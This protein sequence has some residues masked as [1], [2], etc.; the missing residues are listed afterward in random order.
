MQEELRDL[1]GPERDAY[2]RGVQPIWGGGLSEESF[3]AFQRRLADAREA[4]ERH[5]LIGLFDGGRLLAAMKAYDL[6]GSCA[7]RPL[8]I[9]GIGAVFTPPAL[10][11]RGHARRMLE[12]AI[13][14]HAARGADAAMLFSDIGTRYY[15]RLGFRSLRSE[16]C[17]VEQ[18]D[19]P[20]APS[21]VPAPADEADLV[22]VFA[23]GRSNNGDLTLARDGWVLHFQLRR[24]RELARARGV[25]EPEW[26]I[27]V[28]DAGGEGAAMVRIARDAV[29]VL[30][31]A[32]T[33]E[34]S[35]DALLA[36]LR[37]TLVRSGRS[38]LRLWPSHQLRGLFRTRPRSSALAMVAPLRPDV[39]VSASGARADLSL[40]DH[41]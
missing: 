25:A 15:E 7:G 9:L 20:R 6:G 10:R 41:I 39:V 12:R 28:R 14:D 30:D 17:V 40:L 18:A 11:R 29:D 5:R 22:R 13:A 26:G 38:R 33:S 32:W 3:V 36:R 21:V 8:N 27:A 31:A 35:R 4:G 37:E 19:L 16:E 1:S 24:L 2:F 23:R 34:G